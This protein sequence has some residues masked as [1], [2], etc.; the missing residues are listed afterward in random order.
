MSTIEISK[1]QLEDLPRLQAISKQTFVEAFAEF[2]K[3][4]DMEKYLESNL[5]AE[6]L[7]DELRNEHSAFYFA[8]CGNSDIGY[9]KVNINKTD[10][11]NSGELSLEIERLYVVK[12]FY[13]KGVGPLLMEHAKNI[14]KQK[15]ITS[16]WLGVWEKNAQAIH[17]Y[18]K[19][20]FIEFGTHDFLLGEDVQ[21]DILM[22]FKLK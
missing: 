20:G 7:Q 13:G 4:S 1:V 22:R 17:F 15:G 21:I 9:L 6:Q 11:E 2:N 5:S 8:T 10:K 16:I 3:A 19:Q 12:E 18:K 14:A